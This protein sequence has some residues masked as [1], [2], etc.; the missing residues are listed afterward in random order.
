MKLIRNIIKNYDTKVSLELKR[1]ESCVFVTAFDLKRH[2]VYDVFMGKDFIP[3]NYN[4]FFCYLK[5]V[6]N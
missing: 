5:P 3:E 1:Y 4:F 2:R 6:V